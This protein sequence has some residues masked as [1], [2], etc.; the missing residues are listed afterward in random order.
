MDFYK[1]VYKIENK[2][3]AKEFGIEQISLFN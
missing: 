3:Q 2:E 1:D